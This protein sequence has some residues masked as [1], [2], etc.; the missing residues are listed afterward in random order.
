MILG[1]N[2]SLLLGLIIPPLIYALI[3][4]LTAPYRSVSFKNGLLFM[5]GGVVSIT[6]TTYNIFID[7]LINSININIK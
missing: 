1:I 4:Y 5:M 3:I 6:L 2:I 7:T